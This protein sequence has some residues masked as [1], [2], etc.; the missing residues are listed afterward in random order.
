MRTVIIDDEV[1]MRET[2]K[3]L[4]KFYV[5]HI[6]VVAEAHDLHSGI[7]VIEK[8]K[9]ELLLLDI[10]LGKQTAFDLLEQCTERNF[11]LIFITAHDGYAIK[12]F[13]FSA[14]DYVLKPIDPE[15]LVQAINKAEQQEKRPNA[16]LAINNLLENRQKAV[17]NQKLVLADLENI[18][19]IEVNDI[20]RCES[21]SGYTRF[22]LANGEHILITKTLKE[23]EDLL[24]QHDFF[25]VHRAHL[26]NLD[27]FNKLDKKDGGTIHLKDGSL[28]P[29]AVRRKEELLEALARI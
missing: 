5:P 12:A 4:L 22:F 13:K 17:K 25:R 11:N 19:V 21:E 9:P 29:V 8:F 14:I 7:S 1:F 26:I 20:V 10:E 15:D 2:I 3:N 23:Y 27:F 18:Y 6:S 16:D 24:Q 28:L